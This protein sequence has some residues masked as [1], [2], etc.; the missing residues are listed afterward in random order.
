M[1]N[2]SSVSTLPTGLPGSTFPGMLAQSSQNLTAIQHQMDVLQ[3]NAAN[4]STSGFKEQLARVMPQMGGGV[5]IAT[6]LNFAQGELSSG[7]INDAAITGT[8]LFVT[9]DRFNQMIYTRA[10]EFSVINEDN[11]QF[12]GIRGRKAMGYRITETGETSTLPTVIDVTGYTDIG[13][14]DDG[15]IVANATS[16]NPIPIYQ[17]ALAGFHNPEQLDIIDALSYRSSPATGEPYRLA[18][19]NSPDQSLGVVS[20]QQRE[21]SNVNPASLNIE[22]VNLNRLLSMVQNTGFRS[23]DNAY[24]EVMKILGT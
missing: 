11:R 17:V 22:M 7:G 18:A 14:Q 9:L 24:K 8:G 21:L 19:A 5:A 13:F 6:K 2:F 4:M 12:D 1:I 20:G 10:G 23:I 3:R 16:E 15:T